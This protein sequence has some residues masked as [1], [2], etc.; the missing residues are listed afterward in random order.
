[1]SKIRWWW[2]RMTT[3]GATLRF[4]YHPPDLPAGLRQMYVYDARDYD[5][6]RL[7]WQVCDQC[8]RGSI[9]KISISPEWQRR[10]VGR[11]LISRA[12]RDGPS[13][14][15]S[16]SGQSPEAKQF[17][18]ALTAET[19]TA[20]PEYGGGCAHFDDDRRM[21]ITCP[22]PAPAPGFERHV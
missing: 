10:G 9:N 11:R 6:A 15:W 21:P 3:P 4:V 5:I 16:T 20:F 12:L 13:Y 14:T 2:V 18:P 7:V 22:I 17:F 8:G 19:G 1:M